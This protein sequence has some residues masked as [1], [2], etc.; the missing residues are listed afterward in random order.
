VRRKSQSSFNRWNCC[1]GSSGSLQL[2]V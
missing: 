1:S 2:Y